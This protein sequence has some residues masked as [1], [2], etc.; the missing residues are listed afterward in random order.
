M[1]FNW[2]SL[3][4]NIME[5]GMRNS[6]LLAPMPTA[7]TSQILGNNECIEPF[8]SNIYSRGTLAGQ[9]V[10]LNKYLMND[11]QS[12]GVWNNDLMDT[13]ILNNG[14]IKGIASIPEIVRNTY[15]VAWDL[16][17]KSLIDQAADRGAYVCQSQSLN[18]W[19]ED[20]DMSKLS[21]M[22]FYTW[23]KGLKTGIYYLRRRA[24]SKAQTFSI[25]ASKI[26]TNKSKE[27][28]GNDCLMCSS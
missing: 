19:I 9:F 2:D 22:H 28:E 21:S 25:D 27:N 8:T 13:I 1:T 16:S 23:K 11:L 6:L 15:K 26:N 17:M 7:S 12:I 5:T 24:V 4:K 18:L 3:R 14:S 20:P 10:V